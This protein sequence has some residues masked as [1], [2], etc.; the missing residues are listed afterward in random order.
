M[1]MRPFL[2]Q[3]L[4]DIRRLGAGRVAPWATDRRPDEGTTMRSRWWL[5]AAATLPLIGLAITSGGAVPAGAAGAN[6]STRII[7]TH[8]TG[9][10]AGNPFCKRL[11]K[12]YLASA[13]AQMFCFGSQP[14]GPVA[15]HSPVSRSASA[16][17]NVNAASFAEDVSPAGVRLYGQSE[18][19]IAASGPYVVEAW[20]DATS[21]A[22]PC[23]SPMAKEEGTGF[24]FS[25]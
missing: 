9:L 24:G 7:S 5:G 2:G 18:T 3:G 19:S 12:R 13:G 22:S 20:N 17:A 1:K 16:P 8:T 6:H 15:G 11:G 23:P 25:A 4:V 10:A 14:N 21:F